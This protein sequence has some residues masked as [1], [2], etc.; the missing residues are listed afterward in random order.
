MILF[1]SDEFEPSWLKLKDFQL[2]SVRLVAFFFQL[3]KKISARKLKN[4]VFSLFSFDFQ[5]AS[6]FLVLIVA[7][8]TFFLKMTDFLVQKLVKAREKYIF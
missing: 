7:H 2:G 3:G 5:K 1:T 6:L 8:D 4:C